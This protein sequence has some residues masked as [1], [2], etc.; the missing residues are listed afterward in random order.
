MAGRAPRFGR[1]QTL[2]EKEK[3]WVAGNE[4]V[5]FPEVVVRCFLG[6]KSFKFGRALVGP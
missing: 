6:G 5:R 1:I 3:Q 2:H 4:T